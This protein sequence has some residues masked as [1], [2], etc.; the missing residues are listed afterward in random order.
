MFSQSSPSCRT[1]NSEAA[2]P[3]C[4]C[5]TKSSF[6]PTA[7]LG[8]PADQPSNNLLPISPC[9]CTHIGRGKHAQA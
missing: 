5:N 9:V 6:L 3:K 1:E 8:K 7:S 4:T 2:R